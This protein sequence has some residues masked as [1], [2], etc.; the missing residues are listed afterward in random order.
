MAEK[1]ARNVKN[2]KKD[3]LL[4][5]ALHGRLLSSD[6]FAKHWL[7]VLIVIVMILVY[8][9]NK[10]QCMTK[11]ET[12]KALEQELEVVQTERVR[13][14]GEYMSL[15]RESSMQHLVDSL[16]LGLHVQERPP[17]KILYKK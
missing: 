11:M 16:R 14:R 12:I 3:S 5:Q 2:K 17:F 10:Y 1:E 15:I 13:V 8:I 9:T 4:L 7:K 6:F